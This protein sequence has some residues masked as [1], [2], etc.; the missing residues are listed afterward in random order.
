MK[1]K[2][3]SGT[4]VALVSA[5]LGF[6]A[7]QVT[8]GAK[9]RDVTS[10]IA[11]DVREAAVELRQVKAEF[12]N[13]QKRTDARIFELSGLV[14][15]VIESN[16]AREKTMQEFIQVIKVQNELL[17]RMGRTHIVAPR[18]SGDS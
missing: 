5:A 11:A 17:Q 4:V 10:G 12:V 1:E 16:S 6:A 14:K 2:V 7:S 3:V 15:T 8:V 9:V 18:A 13:E